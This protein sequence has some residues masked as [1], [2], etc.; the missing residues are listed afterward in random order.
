M[1]SWKAPQNLSAAVISPT[2]LVFMAT[3][4]YGETELRNLAEGSSAKPGVEFRE[5]SYLSFS[6][7]SR[8]VA[9]SSYLGFARVWDASTWQEVVTLD[10]FL[11][12]ASATAFS[13]DGTRLV[14]AGSGK[15]ALRIW[16]TRNW[17]E[18]LTLAGEGADS[19]FSPDGNALGLLTSSGRLQVWRAPS[20][21]EI[22]AVEAE[23]GVQAKTR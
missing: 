13:P 7:D 19:S 23:T 15:D 10:G 5:C 2:E 6:P 9:A 20:W 16:D 3:G 18:T 17:L 8:L 22:N 14:V 21:R 4:Y 12:G 11:N 1:Q